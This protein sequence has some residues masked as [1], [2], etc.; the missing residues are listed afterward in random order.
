MS[1][2]RS[3]PIMVFDFET[4]GLKPKENT[5]TEFAAIFLDPTSFE[6]VERI[7]FLIKPFF[8]EAVWTEGA[9]KKTGI[10]K[11][12]CEE[13]GVDVTKVVDNICQVCDK[14]LLK[15]GKGIK[16]LLAGQNT[17]FDIGYLQQIFHYAK[18]DMSK[19]FQGDVGFKGEFYP[20][21]FDTSILARTKFADNEKAFKF[22]L[23]SICSM[24]GVDLSDAHKAINDVIATKEV[25]IKYLV[26]MRN[27]SDSASNSQ[28]PKFRETFKF[29]F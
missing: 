3:H 24:K 8:D 7:D 21:Y 13:F 9:S 16:I 14:L 23:A 11:E 15:K 20:F 29:Q 19:Y 22:D 12:K 25:L 17:A 6:E 18:K 10:T 26:A 1:L 28:L 4:S 2:E 27:L 5:A